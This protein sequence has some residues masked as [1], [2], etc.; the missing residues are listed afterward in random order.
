QNI[1]SRESRGRDV[2]ELLRDFPG[3]E[4]EKGDLVFR[5]GK[6]ENNV[7]YVE[8]GKILLYRHHFV[9]DKEMV[10]GLFMQGE[11]IN[12]DIVSIDPGTH[13]YAV[14]R[15]PSVIRAIPKLSFFSLM[16]QNRALVRKVQQGLVQRQSDTLRHL[17]N[18]EL[19]STRQRILYYLVEY[20]EKAGQD[21]G[22]EKVV[23]HF[24]THRELGGLC[25]ASRQS[26]T[27]VLNQLRQMGLIH[28]NR[29]YLL[30]RD[31]EKLREMALTAHL[32]RQTTAS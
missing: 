22:Y 24:L 9:F 26:V 32:G 21:A 27:T 16:V 11:F 7:Y 30:V 6:A 23:R 12:P 15:S 4:Y 8:E 25:N 13:R 2:S 28:F 19:M 18:M 1:F 5:P 10:L 3:R 17:H 29:R 20:T 14:V 31:L